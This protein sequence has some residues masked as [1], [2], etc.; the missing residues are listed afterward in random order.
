M[1]E[2][3]HKSYQNIIKQ[4]FAL[5]MQLEKVKSF[6]PYGYCNIVYDSLNGEYSKETI[7]KVKA[8]SRFNIKILKALINLA[9]KK[10][11]EKQSALPNAVSSGGS[12]KT[13]PEV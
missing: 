2:N 1:Y 4:K 11:K 6:L 5:V 3:K 7:Y 9:R 13:P 10:K 12:R 8:G